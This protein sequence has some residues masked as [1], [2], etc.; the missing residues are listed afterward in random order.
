[1]IANLSKGRKSLK[2]VKIDDCPFGFGC[3]GSIDP[4]TKEQ[5]ANILKGVISNLSRGHKSL[6]LV[7]QEVAS[8]PEVQSP[9]MK[10]AL[11]GLITTMMRVGRDSTALVSQLVG[12][13]VA[14]DTTDSVSKVLKELLKSKDCP[15][16]YGEGCHGVDSD[17]MPIDPATKEEVANILKGMIKN[18]SGH[19]LV[20][21][22][23]S[24]GD[25]PFGYGCGGGTIDPATKAQVANILKGM[26]KS[27]SGG[28][29]NLM[30]VSQDVASN[31]AVQSP[32]MK[33]ALGGL[34]TTMVR[35]GRDST[36]L[37]SQLV[38]SKV[39]DSTTDSVSTVLKDLLKGKDC[40]FGYGEGC[41]GVDS[42]DMPIDP[43]TKEEVANILKGMIKNLSGHSLMQAS[44][45]QAS[46]DCP[47]G[48]GCGGGGTIDPATK[49][50]VAN[51]L[52]GM[53][54]NL[55]G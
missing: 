29:R 42:E 49:A 15:F 13:K 46:D 55:S 45:S 3:G 41:H 38:G 6:K 25:C 4:A 37:V 2:L 31:P 19:S 7:S 8:N 18:L 9:K 26:I 51:I 23:Q 34:I 39:A 54:K 47:F 40:P 5:V 35:V 28:H 24:S 10:K 32:Q 36:A 52:K 12:S 17:E 43:A 53:I 44:Q 22:S 21:E 30:Q 20:Q 50:Q 14:E 48:Y 11:G 16:G 33:K 27:L 1:M